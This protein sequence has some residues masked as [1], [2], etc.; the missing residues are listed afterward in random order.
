MLAGS[1]LLLTTLLLGENNPLH[2]WLGLD[3]PLPRALPAVW[4]IYGLP[5]WGA[6]LAFCPAPLARRMPGQSGNQ[7]MARAMLGC[8]GWTLLLVAGLIQLIIA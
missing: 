4:A 8:A 5:C 1:T 7:E 2:A 3:R 6:A